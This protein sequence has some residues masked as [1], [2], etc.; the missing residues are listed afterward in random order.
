MRATFICEPNPSAERLRQEL[1]RQFGAFGDA[2]ITTLLG[3]FTIGTTETRVN[4][5]LNAIPTGWKEYS[6]RGPGRVY[7][8]RGPDRTSL[9][10]AA[11]SEV[12]TG[13]EVF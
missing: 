4:H 13:I 10:L 5:G 6:P 7:E 1:D 2:A 3:R 12:S 11:T 8:T 9:Y